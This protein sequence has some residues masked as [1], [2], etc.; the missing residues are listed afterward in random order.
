V[1]KLG[2]A[3]H[4]YRLTGGPLS[5]RRTH[6][7]FAHS[8]ICPVV[9]K[10]S[11]AC[12]MDVLQNAGELKEA[13]SA[14]NFEHVVYLNSHAIYFVDESDG[15]AVEAQLAEVYAL[16]VYREEIRRAEQRVLDEA[17]ALSFYA[18]EEHKLLHPADASLETDSEEDES[19]VVVDVS[20]FESKP[21]PSCASCLEA[22]QDENS[23][24]ML[25]C[26]HLYCKTCIATRSRMGVSDRSMV[27]AHCCKR[28]FP[29]DYVQEALDVDEFETYERFRKEKSWR[30]FDLQSD[31]EYAAVVQRNGGV[32][33]PGCGVGVLKWTGC[34]HM[35]CC[36]GHHFCF[37]C[38]RQWKT[39]ACG[40]Y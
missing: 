10:T 34:N 13:A 38:T 27:P 28:E 4:S 17:V 5:F 7:T 9:L 19:L 36:N 2:R 26:G 33:C 20:D 30:T 37:L 14:C 23:R 32:Q 12:A 24:R 40:T 22:L 18:K 21:P 25:S 11:S 1:G 8:P 35:A 16:E 31:R 39:C 29:T 3:M 15:V 6:C